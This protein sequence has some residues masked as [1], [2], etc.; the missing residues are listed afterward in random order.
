[1]SKPTTTK[2]KPSAP[3][4]PRWK[5]HQYQRKAVKFLLE[6]YSAGLLL[7]PGLGKT[8]VTVAA[9]KIL[10]AEGVMT[11]ALVVAPLRPVRTTW[12]KELAKWEDFKE[13]DLVVL[14]GKDFSK[15][16]REKHDFYAINYEGLSKLFT[17]RKVGKVWKPEITED[18]K[19]LMKNVN[20]LVWDEL[21]KMKNS[22]SLRFTLIKPWLKKFLI[23][24]GLTGSPAS[25]GLEDLF[26]QC[27]VLDEGRSLG[28]FI[29][30]YRRQYFLPTADGFGWHVKAGAEPAIYERLKP[31]VLRM[32]ADDYLTLPKQLDHVI[33]F[34]LPASVRDQYE[35]M[36]NDLLTNVADNL[37]TASN[38]G[39]ASGKC[40]QICSGA[41]YL[42]ELDPLTGAPRF[43][44]S[45]R[46]WEL[47]HSEKLD[48]LQDLVE[49]LQGQ[50]LLVAYDFNHDLERLLERFPNTPYIGGGVSGK[51]GE[52]I[53]E[54]WNKGEIPLLFGHPASIG[55]GLNLQ[56]SSAHHV[57]WFTLTWDFELY[58]QFNRRLR[59]QGN[60]AGNMHVYHL[61]AK[62]TVEES[63]YY[64]LRRKYRDQKKLLD[65][66]KTRKR[67]VD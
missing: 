41:V 34:E 31:L 53:E 48:I 29:T 18:G 45:Q 44:K 7:D 16:C 15:L 21:S 23:R 14:H 9:S 19:A 46:Q 63:V 55:H 39:G 56:E 61:V 1:M 43:K 22:S 2:K 57:A 6:H 54:A 47:L 30:H 33:K 65:A 28:Q 10:L 32:D 13:L 20:A 27:Y 11:G 3:S 50:Q 5:P 60:T 62:D 38:A 40:R 42:A 52:Q 24:W 17:R 37:I 4:K 12:P 49:E 51:R 35:E 66:L 64:A 26:G 8:S 36:E 58:D 67:E 25:N 59:R